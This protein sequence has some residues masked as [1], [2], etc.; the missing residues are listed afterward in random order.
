MAVLVGCAAWLAGLGLAL[1]LVAPRAV[2]EAAPL[3]WAALGLVALGAAGL[4]RAWP[5][6]L[7]AL[8][9]ALLLLG[10]ARGLA[11]VPA[12]ADDSLAPYYG[13]VALRGTVAAPAEPADDSVRLRLAVTAVARGGAG[14]ATGPAS[15]ESATGPAG[16]TGQGADGAA[17]SA[18]SPAAAGEADAAGGWE[19]ADGIVLLRLPRTAPY[20]YGDALEARGTLRAP[21]SRES[22]YGAALWRQGVR[23]AMDYPAVRTLP[24]AGRPQPQAALHALRRWLE[25]GI[26]AALP[27]PHAGLLVGVLLGGSATLP[28]TFRQD[29][30]TVGLTHVVAVSGFN[31]T[32]VAAVLAALAGRRAGWPLAAAGVVLYTILVGAPPSATRAALMA[33]L[34]LAAEAAGRPRDGLTALAL[35]AALQ[36]AWDPLLLGD[37]G[38]QLSVLATA[39]LIVLAPLIQGWLRRLP[40]WAAEGLAATLA[41]EL[42]VLPLQ[43]TTFHYLSLVAPLANL[44][45]VP[46]LPPLMALGLGVALVGAVAPGVAPLVSLPVWAYLE[47][48]VRAVQALA[49]LP[50]ARLEVGALPAL[51]GAA[52]GLAL[53][54]LALAGAPEAAGLRAWLRRAPSALPARVAT[55]AVAAAL[56]LATGALGT[57]AVA[58]VGRSDSRLQVTVLDVGQGDATL[59][60]TPSGRVLLVDGGPSPASLMAHLGSRLGLAERRLDVVALTHPHEDHVA[61]LMEAVTRYAVGQVIEG[62]TDYPSAAT[63]RWHALLR[64]RAVPRVVGESGQRWQLDD[65]VTLDVW[66]VPAA[67]GSRAD[68]LEPA[69]ALVLRLRYGATSMLL[70]GDLVAEQGLR[71]VAAGGDLRATALLV[72]H[73]G[74]ATGLDGDLLGAISPTLAVVSDGERNRFGH[75]APRA[76]ALLAAH[77][78]PVWRTDRDGTITLTSDGVAWT[79]QPAGKGR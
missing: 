43:L 35:A 55:L 75:P 19:P 64:E 3:G 45:V 33:L 16:G 62:A 26:A 8:A 58:A 46:L 53:V 56:A 72:P 23:G 60:R 5:L 79:V 2:A 34:A 70:P 63:E 57:L 21:P 65:D 71:I 4:A 54:A 31:V 50:G 74:S 51:V 68:R 30:R 13:K 25:A 48:I 40:A 41:A 1:A 49:A 28:D 66:A 12:L 20:D 14:E 18:S 9:A 76:L 17:A 61:G 7:G 77:A 47:L 39:G 73:H 22:G 52:Y 59:V 6:R 37:L 38:F 32:I 11:I 67:P 36:A 78:V 69:G 24:D 42:F 10:W 27:E 29:M 44:L 15:A